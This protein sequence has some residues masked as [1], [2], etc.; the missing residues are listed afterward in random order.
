MF[1]RIDID[2]W[3]L[4]GVTVAHLAVESSQVSVSVFTWKVAQL[5]SCCVVVVVGV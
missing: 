1:P 3:Y 5:A 4:C 2:I